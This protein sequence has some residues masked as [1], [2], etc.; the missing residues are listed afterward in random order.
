MLAQRAGQGEVLRHCEQL[1]QLF[2]DRDNYTIPNAHCDRRRHKP[3]MG[4]GQRAGNDVRVILVERR[5]WRE[6][7]QGKTR[8]GR[9]VR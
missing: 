1:I 2:M 6:I 9:R 5:S 3:L 8:S 7:H 4:I